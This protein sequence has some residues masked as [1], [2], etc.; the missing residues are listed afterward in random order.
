MCGK[1]WVGWDIEISEET[2]PPACLAR[3]NELLLM[4]TLDFMAK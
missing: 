3:T 1:M 2:V 4:V